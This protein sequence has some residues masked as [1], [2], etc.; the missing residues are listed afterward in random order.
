MWVTFDYRHP[1]SNAHAVYTKRTEEIR[2]Y[3]WKLG[4]F[5]PA[6][7]LEIAAEQE[8]RLRQEPLRRDWRDHENVQWLMQYKPLKELEGK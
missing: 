4:G 5:R 7:Q 6:N 3:E 8:R 2:P 1:S